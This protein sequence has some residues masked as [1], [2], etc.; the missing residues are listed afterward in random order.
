M[1]DSGDSTLFITPMQKKILIDGGGSLN[2]ENYDVGKSVLLPY[3][4]DRNISC[5]DYVFISHFD[6]DH[7][8]GLLYLMENVKIKTLIFLKQEK[9]SQEYKEVMEIV[10]QKKIKIRTLKAGDKIELEKDIMIEVLYPTNEKFED[11]NNNSIV[12]KLKYGEFKMLFTGDIEQKAEKVILEQKI[13]VSATILKIAHHGSKG[14]TTE[15]FLEKVNPQIA[16]IGVGK[17]NFGHPSQEVLKRLKKYEV[18]TYR[19]DQNGEICI[20]VNKQGKVKISSQI[21]NISK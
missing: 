2:R 16:V 5:L 14:S 20:T 3:L 18:T 8:G 7:Y 9:E 6:T 4:L 12:L 15:E 21:S 19:T 10:N 11:Q 17:N 1:L 13:D